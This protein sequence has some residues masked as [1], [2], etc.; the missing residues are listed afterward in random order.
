MNENLKFERKWTVSHKWRM[1][2]QN[3]QEQL[4]LNERMTPRP[5]WTE[6]VE[7]ERTGTFRTE[8]QNTQWNGTSRMPSQKHRS[9]IGNCKF[10]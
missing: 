1:S 3:N 4:N 8:N 6:R 5:Q 2:G 7:T 9:G 10:C